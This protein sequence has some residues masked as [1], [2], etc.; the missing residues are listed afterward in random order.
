MNILEIP[1]HRLLNIKR[2]NFNNYTFKIEERSEYLNHLG[3]IHASAQVSLA[4]ATSGEFLFQQFHELKNDLI[5]VIRKTEMR[6]H[7]PANGE[8]FSKASFSTSGKKEILTELNTRKRALVKVKVEV[9]DSQK[10]KAATAVFDWF[11][12]KK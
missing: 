3:T 12:I 9:F 5:P 11:I 7:K 10:N 6:Y 2:D 4:E 1:F 8:L